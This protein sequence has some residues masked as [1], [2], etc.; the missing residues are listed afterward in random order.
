[1]S[2]IGSEKDR[3]IST[4]AKLAEDKRSL[5]GDMILATAVL[6]YLGPFDGKFRQKIIK[7]KW[8]KF[9]K[10]YQIEYTYN[11]VLK[12]IVG[13]EE[14]ITDWIIKGLPNERASIENMII[15]NESAKTHYPIL[16]DPQG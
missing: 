10:K 15:M 8:M 9:V 11:F 14:K 5:L 7:E 13:N 3:W 6:S 2:S 12:D 1:M 4:K 16:I